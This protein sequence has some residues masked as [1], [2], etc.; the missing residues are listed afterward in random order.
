M[1]LEYQM[2][3]PDEMVDRRLGDLGEPDQD[4]LL[5]NPWTVE[6]LARGAQRAGGDGAGPG[7]EHD[8]KAGG[9]NTAEATRLKRHRRGITP[10]GVV[11]SAVGSQRQE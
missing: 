1:R 9:C 6:A 8:L 4:E 5:V 2:A 7:L 3:G 11:L 10:G